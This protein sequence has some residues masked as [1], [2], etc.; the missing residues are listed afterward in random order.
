MRPAWEPEINE[1]WNIVNSIDDAIKF[2]PTNSRPFFAIGKKHAHKLHF[3]DDVFSIIR[4]IEAPDSSFGL[5]HGELI[6]GRPT[7]NWEAECDLFK[8]KEITH[9][10]LRNSGGEVGFA[11]IKAARNLNI[12]I[13]MIKR[14]PIPAGTVITELED[15]REWL[16]AK[17]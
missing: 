4:M 10:V 15:L 13:I 8:N 9:L 12:S 7:K 1:K 2:L 11:K 16:I 5:S 17:I 14:P 6:L 3:R